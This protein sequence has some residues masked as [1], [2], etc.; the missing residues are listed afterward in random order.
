MKDKRMVEGQRVSY[1]VEEINE[2]KE[3]KEGKKIIS[4]GIVKE[5]YN[6]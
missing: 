5:S 6:K 1:L 3:W 2:E 4:G